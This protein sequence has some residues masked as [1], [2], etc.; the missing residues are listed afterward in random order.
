MGS[1]RETAGVANGSPVCEIKRAEM[2]GT[3][4]RKSERESAILLMDL[5]LA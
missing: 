2:N 3:S 4:L 1:M 5:R